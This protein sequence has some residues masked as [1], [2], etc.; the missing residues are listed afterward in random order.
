VC[1]ISGS[2]KLSF[3]EEN[4]PMRISIFATVISTMVLSASGAFSK[5]VPTIVQPIG[6]LT[7]PAAETTSAFGLVKTYQNNVEVQFGFGEKLDAFRPRA[8]P[9]TGGP[10][11]LLRRTRANYA[12]RVAKPLVEMKQVSTGASLLSGKYSMP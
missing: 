10:T 8:V 2:S 4:L 1:Y 11:P 6:T 9:T 12:Q 3:L 5:T 7:I